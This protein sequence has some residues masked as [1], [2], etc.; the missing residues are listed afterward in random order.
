MLQKTPSHFCY[1]VTIRGL[2]M[3]TKRFFLVLPVIVF[4]LASMVYVSFTQESTPDTP[5][6]TEA[7]EM[8]YHGDPDA[9]QACGAYLDM[10]TLEAPPATTAMP[11]NTPDAN[12]ATATPAPATSTP[13]PAPTVDN[14]GFPEAYQTEFKLFFIFNRPD[15]K[16]LRIICGNDIAAQRLP[17][18]DFAYGSVLL[19][20]SYSTK[21]DADGLPVM[22]ENGRYI[23]Q[24]LVALHVQRKEEGFGEAYGADRNGEWE[25]MA[26][27]ADGSVQVAPQNTNFCAACHGGEAGAGVDYVF[28]MN[29]LY[30][31]ESALDLPAL[32]ENEVIIS[33]YN[34]H[35][36]VLEVSVG[37][38][39]TWINNDEANHR[40]IAAV[41]NAEGRIVAADDPLFDSDILI[42]TNIAAGDSYSFTFTEAGEYLYRCTIHENMTARIIVT[43]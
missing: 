5:E 9:L 36:P 31:G 25:Y 37:T 20:I 28:R 8:V 18:E 29:M 12:A 6:A 3:N 42:S 13:R 17:G 33:L 2:Q 35:T 26:Y 39:V 32:G 10:V 11:T 4:A 27:N 38:T 16:F 14:V 24:N 19:M 34:F 43:E 21:L 41:V 30:E 22:D 23:G 1:L 7:S 40:V 15:R